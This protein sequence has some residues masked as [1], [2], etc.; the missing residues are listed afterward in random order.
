MCCRGVFR[1]CPR[2]T[3]SGRNAKDAVLEG[4]RHLDKEFS[5]RKMSV[6]KAV[7]DVKKLIKQGMDKLNRL[8]SK[9]LSLLTSAENK[10]LSRKSAL[11]A[12][13]G[14]RPGKGAGV[15]GSQGRTCGLH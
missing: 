5:D 13:G 12:A 6:A 10:H 15:S 2:I 3:I 1:H 7:E 11:T 4:M 14:S 9:V 8:S